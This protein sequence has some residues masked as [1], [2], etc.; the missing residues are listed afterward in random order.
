M[1]K[2][3]CT[4]IQVHALIKG[5]RESNGDTDRELN[6]MNNSLVIPLTE[7][8]PQSEHEMKNGI[9]PFPLLSSLPTRLS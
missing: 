7:H 4:Q 2:L 8:M 5:M 1:H 6:S 9:L 3:K